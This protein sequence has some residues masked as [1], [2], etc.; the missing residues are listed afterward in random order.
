MRE[1]DGG[2]RAND[3]ASSATN[4]RPNAGVEAGLVALDGSGLREPGGLSLL[5]FDR[6]QTID[7]MLMAN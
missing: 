1:D 2:S 7:L 5:T 4:S 6:R 3:G